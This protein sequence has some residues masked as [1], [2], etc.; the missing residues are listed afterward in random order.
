MS[1]QERPAPFPRHVLNLAPASRLGYFKAYTVAHPALRQADQAVWN[2]LREPA[3][4]ALIF[5]V[6]PTGV[7][8]TT[9]LAQIEQRLI[10]LAVSHGEP[11]CSHIPALRLDAVSPALTQFKWGDYYQ[12]ALLLLQEPRVEYAV[13]HRSHVPALTRHTVEQNPPPWKGI[14][15]TAGLR[16][17]F[18]QALKHR[19]PYAMLIDEAEHIAK[20][21]R[22]QD[23]G[24]A[25]AA[26]AERAS[27]PPPYGSC[28]LLLVRRTLLSGIT[29]VSPRRCVSSSRGVGPAGVGTSTSFS[30]SV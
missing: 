11:R 25:S 19:R 27:L 20:A 7:G 21:A 6:G 1:E 18:E 17:I 8:K 10:D 26:P 5:V 30:I 3:G 23:V 28:C 14:T 22:E 24:T 29:L 13:D 2:A 16:L 15:D 4:A 9:L 12:R